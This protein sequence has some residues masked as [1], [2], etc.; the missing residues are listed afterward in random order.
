[1]V[2]Y[3]LSSAV[4]TSAPA[5]V[6]ITVAPRRDPSKDP[7]VIGLLN[8]QVAAAERFANAQ[9]MNFNQRLESLHEDG[10][11]QDQQGINGGSTDP[12]NSNA[13]VAD[14]FGN[15]P[16]T[17]AYAERTRPGSASTS[18]FD[19]MITKAEPRT[20]PAGPARARRDFSFWSSGYVNFGNSNNVI[21]GSGFDFTTSGVS[22][23]ADYRFNKF[24][25]A[26]IGIGYGRDRTTVGLNGTE[27]RAEIY[28]VSLC[29]SY[30]PAKGV[31]IDGILGFSSPTRSEALHRRQWQLAVGSRSGNE[32]LARCRPATNIARRDCCCSAR[33]HQDGQATL[34]PFTETATRPARLFSQQNAETIIG[35][36]GFV[37]NTTCS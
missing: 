23:G 36:L 29:E 28:S 37:A 18:A 17:S 34:D 27:S 25:T 4:A 6:T 31:F 5:T 16:G 21:P 12:A 19:R 14:A 1:V 20:D 24:V 8:A 13:Y 3:T 33:A 35:V 15:L 22:V 11:G 26:G 10:Y 30:R 32:W 2:T 7:E 9:M